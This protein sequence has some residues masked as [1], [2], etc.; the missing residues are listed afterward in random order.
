MFNICVSLITFQFEIRKVIRFQEKP[1]YRNSYSKN[2]K[3]KG[4][5]RLRRCF[6][7]D[8]RTWRLVSEPMLMSSSMPDVSGLQSVVVVAVGATFS[9]ENFIR[10]KSARMAKPLWCVISSMSLAR[11]S[12]SP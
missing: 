7:A 9:F 3:S 8:K 4:R 6:A 1:N 12:I 2:L 5:G 10:Q 11:T